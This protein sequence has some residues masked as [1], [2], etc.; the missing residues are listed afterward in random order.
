MDEAF[1]LDVSH[2]QPVGQIWHNGQ[3]HL[4]HHQMSSGPL[5]ARLGRRSL[6]PKLACTWQEMVE[7]PNWACRVPV[8]LCHSLSSTSWLGQESASQAELHW[9]SSGTR[10]PRSSALTWWCHHRM[11][12]PFKEKGCPALHRGS[13]S[14]ELQYVFIAYSKGQTISCVV[15]IVACDLSF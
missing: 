9:F 7:P 13:L 1:T 4:A 15:Y 5:G 11:P 12:N 10:Q 14:S 2:L 8:W 6:L 3:S